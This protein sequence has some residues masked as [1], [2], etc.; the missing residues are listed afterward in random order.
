MKG[1]GLMP[2]SFYSTEQHSQTCKKIP[3][4]Y[5]KHK[6]GPNNR[7]YREIPGTT[8]LPERVGTELAAAGCEG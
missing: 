7:P 6:P 4:R 5:R 3:C 8:P 1:F 2:G